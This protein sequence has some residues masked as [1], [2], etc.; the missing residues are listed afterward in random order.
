MTEPLWSQ[1]HHD[2]S[3][4]YVPAP[5]LKLGGTATVFLR[6]PRTSDVANGWVRVIND[7]EP[8]LVRATVDRQDARATWLRA[9]LPVIR[10]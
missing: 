6:V 2:G 9:E 4:T 5:N 10:S 7:G 1:P 8:E 3:T